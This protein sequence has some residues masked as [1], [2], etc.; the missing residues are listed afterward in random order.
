MPA[1]HRRKVRGGLQV[2]AFGFQPGRCMVQRRQVGD[3]GRGVARGRLAL[4]GGHYQDVPP[5][6][7]RGVK[8]VIEKPPRR[9]VPLG[10]VVGGDQCS[11]VLTKQVI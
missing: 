8:V 7:E 2:G 1:G 11:G 6:G 10:W 9:G 5:G 4:G 3:T